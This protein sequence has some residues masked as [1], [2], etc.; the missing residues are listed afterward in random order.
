MPI[1]ELRP[2]EIHPASP[3][4]FEAEGIKERA[5]LQRLL[6][7]RIDCL[8]E[9][10]LVLAEEFSDWADSSRRIDLLCLD[11]EANLVVVEL[12]RTEDGGH[13]ELQA[14]RYAAMVST[15]RFEQAVDALA[16][17]RDR[18]APDRDA[19]RADILGFLGWAAPD[20]DRFASVTRLILVAADFGKELTTTVLWLREQFSI[21]IRCIRLKAYRLEDGKRLLDIQQLIPLP[22]AADYQTKLGEK[23]LAERNDQAE[24]HDQRLAFWAALL[25]RAKPRTNLHANRQPARDTWISGGIGRTGFMLNYVARQTDSHVELWISK[26]KAAFQKLHAD[27]DAI[28]QEFGHPL[29]WQELPEASGA[30]IRFATQG[31]YRSPQQDWPA[32]QDAMIDAMIR[33][34]QVF[35]RRVAAL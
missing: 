32:I 22:E 21:D 1:Y 5:D 4:T 24:R 26:D 10:L 30:R 12:K 25:A 16:R 28:D 8:E 31:G 17:S 27:R 35:R 18:G 11:S 13:M 6:K 3:T 7:Q 20:E 23:R 34:D 14:L 9:G 15:M 2:D 33:M 29:D 19:A